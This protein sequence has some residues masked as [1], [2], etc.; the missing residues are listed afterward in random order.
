MDGCTIHNYFDTIVN[1]SQ[2]VSFLES[3]RTLHNICLNSKFF[4][5][6]RKCGT[7]TDDIFL[8]LITFWTT[9]SDFEGLRSSQMTDIRGQNRH[10]DASPSGR[11][12]LSE[13][14]GSPSSIIVILVLGRPAIGTLLLVLLHHG[15]ANDAFRHSFPLHH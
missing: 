1:L 12:H 7:E 13:C 2:I 6:L 4:L 10:C 15:T 5:E 3:V 9:S 11:H 8:L 14:D